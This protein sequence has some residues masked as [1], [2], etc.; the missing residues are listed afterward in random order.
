MIELKEPKDRI[1]F[2][3]DVSSVVEAQKWVAMLK[4]H[5]GMFKVGLELQT[6]MLA[7][8]ISQERPEN[9]VGRALNIWALFS[10]SG[11]NNN[12][13]WDGKFHD[14]PRTMV[15]AARAAAKLPIAMFNIHASAYKKAIRKAVANK[16]D[17][18]VLG[19]T[20]LTS[21][22]AEDCVSV[23]GKEPDLKVEQF[24]NFLFQEG[25]DGIICSPQETAYLRT[26]LKRMQ[27]MLIVTP[28]IRPDWAQKNDQKRVM[29]PG[30]AIRAGAD[31]LVIGEPISN[32]PAKIGT[33]VDA[34]KK[35]ADEIAEALMEG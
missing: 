7:D 30:E 34:A 11:L 31:Y 1:I 17:K 22:E 10:S 5:V 33:P 20:V 8:I 9:V 4:P 24:A 6:T 21:L 14:I 12:V 27:N 25:A 23:F 35:I 18:K 32:P 15:G 26:C 2:P 29:T 3:L 19:V 16:G 13:F 28:G